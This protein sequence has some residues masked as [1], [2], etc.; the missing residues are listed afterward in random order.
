MRRSS[1]SLL[2]SFIL[3][4]LLAQAGAMA[5]EFSHLDGDTDDAAEET[6]VFCLAAASLDSA[7]SLPDAPDS[8]P[9]PLLIA[10]FLPLGVFYFSFLCR[11]YWGR[12]PPTR[13]RFQ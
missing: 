4:F 8:I 1:F 11:A 9:P 5:H 13:P 6:C 2:L 7:A 3:L 12:A 10:I